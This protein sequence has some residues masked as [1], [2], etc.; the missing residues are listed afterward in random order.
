MGFRR[1]KEHRP[2]RSPGIQKA[3]LRREW[4]G[5]RRQVGKYLFV[6]R[7]RRRYHRLTGIDRRRR[8]HTRRRRERRRGNIRAGAG[9][10]RRQPADRRRATAGMPGRRQRL[11]APRRQD[12][13]RRDL[14]DGT[15]NIRRQPPIAP[16]RG[17]RRRAGRGPR[18]A[19]RRQGTQRRGN[20][21][22][23]RTNRLG[24]LRRRNSHRRRRRSY[25]SNREQNIAPR[26]TRLSLQ[27]SPYR[28]TLL[29][30]EHL[31]GMS[32]PSTYL[33]DGWRASTDQ[34]PP[35]IRNIRERIHPLPPRQERHRR[36]PGQNGLVQL[37]DSRP[38]GLGARLQRPAADL[39]LNG[40]PGRAQEDHPL[41]LHQVLL[42]GVTHL[43]LQIH[44][45]LES[46]QWMT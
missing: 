13:R 44:H 39:A 16:R 42:S 22:R 6:H 45:L 29:G 34:R 46:H 9:L 36:Q 20:Q 18:N 17:T 25:L 7:R 35:Q 23:G 2:P 24:V 10:R 41:G 21:R 30:Q 37:L 26:Q 12:T 28:A 19:V 27:W 40:D 3:I 1:G 31:L 33:R 15:E 43:L 14:H 8:R 4:P 38:R 11:C 5:R 32:R